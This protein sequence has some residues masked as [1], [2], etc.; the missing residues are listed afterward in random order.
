MIW[1]LPLVPVAMLLSF[2]I[3]NGFFYRKVRVNLWRN[4]GEMDMGPWWMGMC[5]PR[6]QATQIQVAIIPLNWIIMWT[7]KAYI[8]IMH[9][10]TQ[11]IWKEFGEMHKQVQDTKSENHKM[12]MEVDMWKKR[13][14]GIEIWKY[15]DA[16]WE[17]RE[18]LPEMKD[19]VW[20]GW[21][22]KDY[23]I[24]PWMSGSCFG[25]IK[26]IKLETGKVVM[27]YRAPLD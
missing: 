5:F 19:N 18:G 14:Q 20:V 3:S 13:N 16:P 6:Y 24:P 21:V 9:E 27:S 1:P 25:D 4:I 17:L 7:W 23:S 12:R 8:W 26:V 22:P 11:F 15:K 10:P 2:L